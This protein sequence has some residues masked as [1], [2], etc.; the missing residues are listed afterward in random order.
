MTY[1]DQ[2]YF[3]RAHSFAPILQRR[4][5][6]NWTNHPN[7]TEAQKALQYAIWT[8]ASVFSTQLEYLRPTLHAAALRIL[9]ELERSETEPCLVELEH[10]QARVLLLI[11]DLLKSSFDLVWLGACKAFRLLQYIHL[12]EIDSPQQTA[13][14]A[15]HA[16]DKV[17][18]EEQRRTFW[19]GY[20][21]DCFINLRSG[22]SLTFTETAAS[23]RLPAPEEQFQSGRCT[24]QSLLSEVMNSCTEQ[25]FCPFAESV[26]IATLVNRAHMH[27]QQSKLELV[28]SRATS[29]VWNRHFWIEEA[30]RARCLVLDLH[31]ADDMHD[32]DGLLLSFAKMAAQ[33]VMLY[34]CKVLEAKAF[35][36][37]DDKEAVNQ[38]KERTA[39]AA[40]ELAMLSIHL[41][42]SS[43]FKVCGSPLNE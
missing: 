42:H 24:R 16:E 28:Y 20:T 6:F 27:A 13:Q 21:I 29:Q 38:V 4:K 3:E 22:R 33:C 26:I 17:Y 31:N 2:I 32:A 19:C 37:P 41:Q 12:H 35:I 10:A 39:Q 36:T 5:Y 1:R 8:L 7:K 43:A 18:T 11:H 34:L 23:V 14:R 9:D 40:H 30:L 15:S 25:S